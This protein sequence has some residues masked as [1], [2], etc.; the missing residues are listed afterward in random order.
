M[1]L[2]APSSTQG[3]NMSTQPKRIPKDI[4]MHKASRALE[5]VYSDNEQYRLSCEYLRVQSPSAEVRGH[6]LGNAVLQTGK[7][8]VAITAINPVGNYALQLS[9]DD[10]HDSGIYSW[11][12][13]EQL[14]MEHQQRWDN[15]LEALHKAGA[16]RDND[17]QVL[18]LDNALFT[19]AD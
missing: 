18:Q 15:Y 14:C 3:I 1:G 9:F 8:N 12:Y 6:G 5:L 2:S 4:I 16:S 13:L 7:K 17:V 11:A 19:K 10:G